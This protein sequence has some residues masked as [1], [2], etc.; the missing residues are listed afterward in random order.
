MLFSI[1]CLVIAASNLRLHQRRRNLNIKSP[2]PFQ[3]STQLRVLLHRR[4]A[5]SLELVTGTHSVA[6]T[7]I[8]QAP[9]LQLRA[10]VPPN[11]LTRQVDALERHREVIVDVI[12]DAEIDL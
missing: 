7:L 12:T 6:G 5:R 8:F 10:A 3:Q 9:D 2:S 4:Q 11:V 1:A